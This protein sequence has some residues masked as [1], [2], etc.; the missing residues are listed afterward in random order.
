MRVLVTGAAGYVGSHACKALAQAGFEP[1]GLDSMERAGIETLPWGPLE[2]A[3]IGDGDATKRVL[4]RYRPEAVLHFA[5]YAYVGESVAAPAMYYRNNIGGSVAL[6]SALAEAGI[7]KFVFSSSCAVYGLPITC[8]IAEDHPQL[9]ISPYGAS[10]QMVERIL[11]DFEAAYGIRHVALRYFNAAGADPDGILGECHDPETHVIP[12]AIQAALGHRAQFDVLG[13]DYPTPDGTAVRDYVHVTD[14]A[15][16]HVLALQHLLH[17]NDSVALNLGTGRGHSV[18]DVVQAVEA[19]TG[20][21]IT[22]RKA[23]R[24]PGDPPELVA[25]P[26]QAAI[27]LD[28]QPAFS[29]LSEIVR[30]AVQWESKGRQASR[31]VRVSAPPGKDR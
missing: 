18:L 13:T 4:Q 1:I 27:V 11:A 25:D 16:A 30:T 19:A 24:R 9:P 21:T 23:G 28:W 10:K 12:L 5:A 2:V 14:L 17:G 6:L 7:D 29:D 26:S 3:D 31:Y 20:K 22:L 15:V 8:P